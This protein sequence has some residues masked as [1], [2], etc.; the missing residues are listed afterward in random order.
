MANGL[1][2]VMIRQ[3]IDALTALEAAERSKM[4]WGEIFTKRDSLDDVFVK[5]VS[6][7]LDEQGEIKREGQNTGPTG[8]PG[9]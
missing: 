9:N 8:R 3:K 2:S 5:L 4:E 7:I 1:I 6:G